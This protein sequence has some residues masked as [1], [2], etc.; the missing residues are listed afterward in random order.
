MLTQV[1][2]L[3]Q[4]RHLRNVLLYQYK[5]SITING[6]HFFLD[7]IKEFEKLEALFIKA[8]AYI[9]SHLQYVGNVDF[10]LTDE[11]ERHAADLFTQ[12][13]NLVTERT[14]RYAQILSTKFLQLTYLDDYGTREYGSF[15]SEIDR[16][17]SKI[18]PELTANHREIA[19]GIILNLVEKFVVA[20]ENSTSRFDINMSPLDYEKYCANAFSL[21]G[22]SAS[23]TSKTGDQGADVVIK[24][25]DLTGVV[26]CKLYSQPVGNA[27]VQEVI[28]AREY[29]KASIAIVVSNAAYTTSARQLAAMAN[30]VLL[31]H[32]EIA[33]HSSRLGVIQIVEHMEVP[34]A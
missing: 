27:A 18:I 22:W 34:L 28:A 14:I 33:Q 11:I 16:F 3:N 32:G 4:F 9:E 26:Q 23:M 29:Y 24:H 15:Y 5:S 19:K 21:A 31:H 17:M 20:N 8:K 1:V 13:P 6:V 10:I 12:L 7:I 30:V 2:S 25:R